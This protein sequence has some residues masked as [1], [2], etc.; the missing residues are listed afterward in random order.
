MAFTCNLPPCSILSIEDSIGAMEACTLCIVY[1]SLMLEIT[2]D[3][4]IIS[5]ARAGQQPM[6]NPPIEIDAAKKYPHAQEQRNKRENRPTQNLTRFGNLPT[7][8]GQG[9]EILLIQQSIQG[10]PEGFSREY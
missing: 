7:S 9:G 1:N 3:L 10:L 6:R 4:V 2:Y 8:S 5:V